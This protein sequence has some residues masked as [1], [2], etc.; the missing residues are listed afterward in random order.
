MDSGWVC[1]RARVHAC[2]RLWPLLGM[3]LGVGEKGVQFL[4]CRVP[5]QSPR[6]FYLNLAFWVLLKVYLPE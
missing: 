6:T 5:V 1:V 2:M 3:E 4:N